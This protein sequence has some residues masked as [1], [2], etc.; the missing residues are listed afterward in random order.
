MKYMLLIY[1]PEQDWTETEWRECVLESKALCHELH[2]MGQFV[3]ASPLHPVAT[4]V[5]VRIRDGQRLVTAGPFAETTEQLGDYYIIDVPDLD[6]AISIAARVPAARKGTVEIR[7]MTPLAGLP[8]DRSFAGRQGVRQLMLICY[9]NE[10]FW[11]AAGPEALE[12]AQRQA[13]ELTRRLDATG[14]YLSASPLRPVS[15]ATSVRIRGGKRMV[16]DGPF[17]ETREFLGGYYLLAVPN[18]AEALEIAAE[19]PGAPAGTVE[20]REVHHLTDLPETCT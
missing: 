17:A 1:S 13:A 20:I 3:S 2:G 11:N 7:P 15:T 16:T 4:A 19:H 6:E 5:S 9:D 14:R 12:A 8:P 18:V 10:E